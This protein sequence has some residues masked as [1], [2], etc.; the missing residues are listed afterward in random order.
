M[1]RK[2]GENDGKIFAVCAKGD[3]IENRQT[4][5]R[6]FVELLYSKIIPAKLYRFISVHK[7][8]ASGELVYDDH[9]SDIGTA[10]PDVVIFQGETGE[11]ENFQ[12]EIL[13]TQSLSSRMKNMFQFVA[14]IHPKMECMYEVWKKN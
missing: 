12:G 2:Y 7:E 11:M 9:I 5:L 10:I 14:V 1:P 13:V 3:S 4:T 6:I 8:P